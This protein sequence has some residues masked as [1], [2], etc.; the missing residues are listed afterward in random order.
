MSK[1]LQFEKDETTGLEWCT[2]LYF[3]Y[4]SNLNIGQ[5][6]WRCRNAKKLRGAVLDGAQL[7]FKRVAD[8]E[9][10]AGKY[11]MGG[12]WRVTR[13]DVENLDKYEGYPTNYT[14]KKVTVHCENGKDYEAFVYA[15][16][17]DRQYQMPD[18]Y[19]YN[20]ILQGYRDFSLNEKNLLDCLMHS[21]HLTYNGGNDKFKDCAM[22]REWYADNE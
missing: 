21:L 10:A 17:E 5:M 11:V 9:K 4:G 3:C 2:L 15:M 14:R 7:V 20:T 19:Y 18:I 22:D 1:Q 16:N 12:L 6:S 8:I 13:Q